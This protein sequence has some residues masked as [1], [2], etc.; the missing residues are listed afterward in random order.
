MHWIFYALA[1]I[2]RRLIETLLRSPSFHN[3][4][5]R[6]HR[7]IQDVRYGRNPDEPLRPGEATEDPQKTKLETFFKHF[8][9]EIRNQARGDPPKK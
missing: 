5:R 2:E 1:D 9:E 4:V 8:I 6:I 3:G 7:V